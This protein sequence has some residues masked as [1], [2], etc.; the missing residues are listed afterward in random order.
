MTDLTQR[1][2][3]LELRFVLVSF[4]DL[5]GIQRAKLVPVSA[6]AGMASEGAGFAGFAAWLDL[7]PPMAMCWQCPIRPA[8][9]LSPGRQASAGWPPSSLSMGQRWPSVRAGCC[10]CSRSGP[11]P[12]V[13]S[14]AAA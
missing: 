14:C 7:S 2:E 12:S 10:G 13:L 4:T 6:L 9:P 3:E 8:S 5:F 1:L 11:P